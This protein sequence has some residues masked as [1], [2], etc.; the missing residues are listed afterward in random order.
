MQNRIAI[1]FRVDDFRDVPDSLLLRILLQGSG[2]TP[3]GEQVGGSAYRH[4]G[5]QAVVIAFD[6]GIILQSNVDFFLDSLFD[7]IVC[8]PLGVIR[9][10]GI[11]GKADVYRLPVRIA[12]SLAALTGTRTGALSPIRTGGTG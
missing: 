5:C 10:V 2:G 9:A 4:L 12:A 11:L 7:G 8:H 3:C 6:T 1:R